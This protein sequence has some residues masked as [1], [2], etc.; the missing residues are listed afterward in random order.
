MPEGCPCGSR[1]GQKTKSDSVHMLT[2]LRDID[3]AV[4]CFTTYVADSD[5]T[6]LR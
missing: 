6:Y 2:L 3:A 1:H 5:P 4:G